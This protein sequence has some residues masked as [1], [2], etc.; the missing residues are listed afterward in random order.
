VLAAGDACASHSGL[1]AA[2]AD[3]AASLR[4]L[5]Q[6]SPSQPICVVT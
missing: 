2:G 6:V 4:A 5:G 3:V 1:L